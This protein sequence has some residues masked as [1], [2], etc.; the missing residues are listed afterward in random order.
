MGPIALY[1][2]FNFR[3]VEHVAD[4]HGEI[5]RAREQRDHRILE[6]HAA[7][8]SQRAIAEKVGCALGLVNSVIK[9]FC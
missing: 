5:Q 7:G 6:L 2:V 3:T 9:R 1:G 8:C 4:E